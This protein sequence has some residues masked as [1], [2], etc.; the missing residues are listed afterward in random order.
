MRCMA[1]SLANTSS[2]SRPQRGLRYSLRALLILVSLASVGLWYWFRVPYVSRAS[3]Q[4]LVAHDDPSDAVDQRFRIVNSEQRQRFRRVLRGEPV[5]D[6]LTEFY[7][8][9]GERLGEESW[10]EGVLHGPWIR[11]YQ[12]GA[13][14]ERGQYSMGEKHGPWE[15]FYKNGRLHVRLPYDRGDP[16]GEAVWYDHGKLIRTVRYDHGEVTH[17]DGHKAFDPLGRAYRTGEIESPSI[18][19]KIV[20]LFSWHS[21]TSARRR[22]TPEHGLGAFVSFAT[23]QAGNAADEINLILDRK[24]GRLEGAIRSIDTDYLTNGTVLVLV[25]APSNF[26]ACHRHGCVWITTKED[27]Q[28]WVDRTGVSDLLKSPPPGA[29]Q[30]QLDDLKQNLDRP[31]TMSFVGMSAADVAKHLRSAERLPID[32]VG[33]PNGPEISTGFRELPL[34]HILGAICEQHDFRVRWG[35]GA[36]LVLEPQDR[37]TR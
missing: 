35:E 30:R 11:R 16:H 29:S 18:R 17:V 12:H 9:T 20:D 13:V 24:C 23:G 36:A 1:D 25:L 19:E 3:V 33:T 22:H 8:P 4:V 2:A 34:R 15:L 31:L 32:W 28:S 26:V 37:G 27:A 21:S 10:R 6:G 7:Y 14:M 5:R